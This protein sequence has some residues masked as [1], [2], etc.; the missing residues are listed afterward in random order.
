MLLVLALSA[1]LQQPPDLIK[2]LETTRQEWAGGLEETGRGVNYEIRL[3]ANKKSAKLKFVSITVDQQ[4]CEYRITN[5]NR[6]EKGDR[7]SKGDTLLI[8]AQLKN[9]PNRP[10]QK[11][12]PYPV[13]GYTFKKALYYFSIRQGTQLD[14]K[15]YR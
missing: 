4:G 2:I 7:F 10:P 1:F 14:A 11:G 9:P 13:I 15:Y 12:K 8:L 5:V 6:P 3:V